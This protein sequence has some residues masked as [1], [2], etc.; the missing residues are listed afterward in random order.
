MV[1]VL[2]PAPGA[3]IVAGENEAVTPLGAAL[4]D[5][6]IAELKDPP[7]AVETATRPEDP[8]MTLRIADEGAMV[9]VGAALMVRGIDKDSVTA[10]PVA[11]T[12][13]GKV[14]AGAT[15]V[16]VIINVAWPEPGRILDVE[17]VALTPC[18]IPLTT[19]FNAVLKPF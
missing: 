13:S 7:F 19:S 3:A 1:S 8:G 14:P 4:S 16:V 2:I 11:V 12:V 5:N 10:P 18:G 6:A 15:L 9:K 17:S